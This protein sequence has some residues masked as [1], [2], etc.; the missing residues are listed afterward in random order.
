MKKILSFVL[1]A[2][3]FLLVSCGED[4]P[5]NTDKLTVNVTPGVA[6]LQEITFTVTSKNA[7]ACAWLCVAKGQTVP[8]GTDIMSKGKVTFA[9]TSTEIKVSDLAY[10]T[11]YVIVAAAMSGD[12]IVTSEPVEMT[13]LP[14]PI[15]PAV[16]LSAGN[17]VGDTYT[18]TITPV[19]AEKCA[20]KVYGKDETCTVE[21]VLST[22][23]EVAVEEA[24]I[25][26]DDLED[27]EYYVVAAVQYGEKTALSNQMSFIISSALPTY[28][29]NPVRVYASYM[30]Q[31]GMDYV[32]M[33]D[34]ID[35]VG[36]R[37]HI[38]L[39]FILPSPCDYLAEGTYV[40]GADAAPKLDAD[41][42]EQVIKGEGRGKFISGYCNV[43]ILDGNYS[44]DISL[45]RDEDEWSYSG[46]VF[47]LKYN[48]AIEYLPIN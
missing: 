1:I 5:V 4:K 32:I 25:T 38:A 19:D 11:T 16:T 8:S 46:H 45:T 23:T 37:S 30:D 41:Y 12:D 21:D 28:T 15:E 17:A 27:G 39:D 43:G 9:N 18:F 34:F 26:I 48:G 7:E 24:E 29:V 31:Y 22:G 2:F 20:Y 36:E 13:T 33:V 14:R 42:T 44:L 10:E 6:D 35:N 3:S 47:T 40:F